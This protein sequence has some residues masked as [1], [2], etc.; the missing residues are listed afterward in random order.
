MIETK[1]LK[2]IHPISGKVSVRINEKTIIY[3]SPDKT[4]G[5]KE[6]FLEKLNASPIAY[7]RP[8]RRGRPRSQ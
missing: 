7:G 8:G 5:A 1:K 4:D 2:I 6:R 3:V